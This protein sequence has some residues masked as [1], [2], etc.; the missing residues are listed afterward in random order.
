MRDVLNENSEE[1]DKGIISCMHISLLSYIKTD[2][3]GERF[4]A[5][6]EANKNAL[7]DK[8]SLINSTG[9]FGMKILISTLCDFIPLRARKWKMDYEKVLIGFSS[10]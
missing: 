6:N 2:R 4:D 10:L 7:L 8:Y 1:N 5:L 9:F 3:E